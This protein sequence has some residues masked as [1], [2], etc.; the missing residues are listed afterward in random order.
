L[1]GDLTE[2]LKKARALQ[3]EAKIEIEADT[4]EQVAKFAACGVDIILLDNMTLEETREAVRVIGGRAKIEAS[5]QMTL[6]RVKAV[7][8][9]GVDFISVGELTHTVRAVDFSLEM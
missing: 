7:A 2:A 1:T 4:L 5:G 9:C 6:D 8:E 3:P